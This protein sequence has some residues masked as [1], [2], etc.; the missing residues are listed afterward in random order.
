MW[1]SSGGHRSVFAQEGIGERFDIEILVIDDGS[2]DRPPSSR[3][4]IRRSLLP[5]EREGTS[6]ARNIGL[7]AESGEYVAFLDDDDS[8]LPWKLRR[9]LQVLEE[10]PEAAPPTV[11]R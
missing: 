11:K 10:Y 6:G 2:T 9:Q 7:V 4:S 1:R 8:W 5:G 3:E